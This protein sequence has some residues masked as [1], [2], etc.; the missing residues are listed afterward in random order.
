MNDLLNEV[1]LSFVSPNCNDLDLI[2]LIVIILIQL[3][4]F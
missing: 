4:E 2:Y 1:T 3:R